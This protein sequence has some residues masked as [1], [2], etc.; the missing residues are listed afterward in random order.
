MPP[1]AE[2]IREVAGVDP[3]ALPD[4]VLESTEPLVLRG[5]ATDWPMVRGARPT[6]TC[7]GFTRTRPSARFSVLLPSRADSSTTKT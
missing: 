1:T 7:A 4:E 3:R 2:N 6:R 5:L